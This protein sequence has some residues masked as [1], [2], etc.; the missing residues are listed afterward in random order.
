MEPLSADENFFFSHHA[1]VKTTASDSQTPLRNLIEYQQSNDSVQKTGLCSANEVLGKL[2][3]RKGK[4]AR[5]KEEVFLTCVFG[6][7]GQGKT[8]FCRQFVQSPDVLANVG[9]Q[10]LSTFISFNQNTAYNSSTDK[11]IEQ[12]VIQRVCA[13]FLDCALSQIPSNLQMPNN[14]DV[15]M[16]VLLKASGLMTHNNNSAKPGVCLLVDE[17]LQVAEAPR[18]ELLNILASLQQQYLIEE[19]PIF[20][21]VTSLRATPVVN[22]IRRPLLPIHLPVLAGQSLATAATQIYHYLLQVATRHLIANQADSHETKMI[23]E[24]EA[25]K[26][27]ECG[28]L[29]RLVFVAVSMSGHHFRSLEYAVKALYLLVVSASNH[30][31]LPERFCSSPSD[32][33]NSVDLMAVGGSLAKVLEK[34]SSNS[35]TSMNDAENLRLFQRALELFLSLIHSP[36]HYH[37]EDEELQRTGRLFAKLRDQNRLNRIVPMVNLPHLF[38]FSYTIAN[39]VDLNLARPLMDHAPALIAGVGKLINKVAKE[40]AGAFEMAMPLIELLRALAYKT[41][42]PAGEVSLAQILPGAIVRGWSDN[43]TEQSSLY[44]VSTVFTEAIIP[45]QPLA[46]LVGD[47]EQLAIAA[48]LQAQ[49]PTNRQAIIVSQQEKSMKTIEYVARHFVDVKGRIPLLLCSMK[50]R[51]ASN[52]QSA[53]S[54]ANDIHVLARKAGL[55]N[56]NYYAV[57]YCCQPAEDINPLA[58]PPGTVVICAGT[59]MQMLH[60][61]GASCLLSLV[62]E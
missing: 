17:L 56:E 44:V 40:L 35:T 14:I 5:N 9:I 48:I 51:E 2:W 61:F 8:E 58:L 19:Y 57:V 39:E 23:K 6:S 36:D 53:V 32:L 54:V 26:V 30:S 22:V 34:V 33:K 49:N 31:Q 50:L 11:D 62:T 37:D 45:I 20:F 1:N 46:T 3:S 16:R 10:L 60:P 25:M 27:D 38:T 52:S 41:S 43:D 7:A 59:V 55:I 12:A 18:R 29:K 24:A 15:M 13:T 4:Q 28:A 47:P 42:N 21:I